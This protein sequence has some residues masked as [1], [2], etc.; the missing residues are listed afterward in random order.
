MADP[1]QLNQVVVNLVLNALQSMDGSGQITLLT[2]SLGRMIALVV[3]DTGCGMSQSTL[4]KIFIPFF[5]T[6]DVGQGTG[7]GLP[8]VHGIVTSHGG[9]IQVESQVGQGTRFEIR[10][11]VGKP[12][13]RK[14]KH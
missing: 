9:T 14:K 5:T 11:P 7:L 2:Q 1:A 3:E 4:D 6:K 12:P 8:V 13:T 10:L